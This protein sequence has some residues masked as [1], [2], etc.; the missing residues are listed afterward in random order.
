MTC[1]RG[2]TN[3]NA[4]G[5]VHD[6]RARRAFLMKTYASDVP[7]FVRCY[8]CGDLLYNPDDVP[9]GVLPHGLQ[10]PGI[11][12]LTIDRIIP[13]CQGGTYRR[14]KYPARMRAMQQ[15]DRRGHA[16][17]GEGIM[18]EQPTAKWTVR[19]D[20]APVLP[21]F[22]WQVTNPAGNPVGNYPT[23]GEALT[24]ADRYARMTSV[25]RVK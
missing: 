12:L 19:L 15:R 3:G 1:E 16:P 17:E 10:L 6:R 25:K 2:T 20:K 11:A 7:G 18:S 8:R 23:P 22:P 9:M 21:S 5:S 24:A 14:N 13:G 4:R